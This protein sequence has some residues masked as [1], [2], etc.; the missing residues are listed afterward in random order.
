MDS[1]VRE[2]RPESLALELNFAIGPAQQFIGAARTT[3]DFWAGSFVLSWLSGVAMVTARELGAVLV[4]PAGIEDVLTNLKE[5]KFDAFDRQAAALPSKFCAKVPECFDPRVV[6]H[7]VRTAWRALSDHVYDMDVKGLPGYTENLEA[8][9]ADQLKNRPPGRLLWDR[10]IEEAFDI[11][12]TVDKHLGQ[13]GRRKYWRTQSRAPQSGVRCMLMPQF[14][15]VS[16][17]TNVAERKAFWQAQAARAQ[18]YKSDAQSDIAADELLCAPALVKRR[19]RRHLENLPDI[20]IATGTRKPWQLRKMNAN[21]KVRDTR[22]LAGLHSFYAIVRMDIDGLGAA[23]EDAYASVSKFAAQVNVIVNALGGYTIYAGGDDVLAF[24]PVANA[25]ACANNLRWCLQ[26][27]SAGKLTASAAV[28]ICHEKSP[29]ADALLQS[30]ALLSKVAKETTGRDALAVQL[31][32]PGSDTQTYSAPWQ[33][34]WTDFEGTAGEQPKL[35]LA[36]FA[37]K[38]GASDGFSSGYLYWLRSY[39]TQINMARKGDAQKNNHWSANELAM[40]VTQY[41]HQQRS[42]DGLADTYTQAQEQLAPLQTI[43]VRWVRVL[44]GAVPDYKLASEIDNEESNFTAQPAL[45]G[46]F[47]AEVANVEAADAAKKKAGKD[48]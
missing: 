2:P 36:E 28:Y 35:L 20:S 18:P 22:E 48:D 5:G 32:K 3:N 25:L 31:C 34:A 26:Q 39:F 30:Q 16:L 4:Y 38:V 9:H 44:M 47:L 19:M 43:S 6:Q 24:V 29:L 40:M 12:W 14:Q 11:Q 41:L 13:F 23:A 21:H 33:K 15:E 10:Q 17:A 42:G 8:S 27:E 46:R 37:T 1:F 7:A 45:I